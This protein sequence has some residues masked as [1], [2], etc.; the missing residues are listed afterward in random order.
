[1][2]I[3]TNLVKEIY[4]SLS[5]EE[6]QLLTDEE[7][8]SEIFESHGPE[9]FL[10]PKE[11]DLPI[12]NPIS[13]SRNCSMLLMALAQAKMHIM[14]LEKMHTPDAERIDFYNQVIGRGNGIY[15]ESDCNCSIK[16]QEDQEQLHS[17]LE[18]LVI[19][20]EDFEELVTL[21]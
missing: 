13:G 8:K 15:E 14:Q 21:F 7:Y 1:M 9:S 16:I 12:I 17:L 20:D 2:S 19:E 3:Y 11:R 10:D 18:V 6:V 5:A 4:K